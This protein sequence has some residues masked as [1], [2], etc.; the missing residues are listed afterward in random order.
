M[1]NGRISSPSLESACPQANAK[2]DKHDIGL[3]REV[4][5]IKNTDITTSFVNG[6]RDFKFDLCQLFFCCYSKL[7][8][9][10]SNLVCIFIVILGS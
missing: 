7:V 8:M 5:I 1:Q 2:L 10:Q 4:S 9:I 6:L 3:W